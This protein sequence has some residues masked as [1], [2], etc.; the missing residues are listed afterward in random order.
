MK[1]KEA[2]KRMRILKLPEQ[3]ISD[4]IQSGKVYKHELGIICQLVE[5]EKKMIDDFEN[6]YKGIV[7]AVIQTKTD[8]GILYSLFYVSE[9]RSEWKDDVD[10]LKENTSMLYVINLE[11]PEFSE[12]GYIG[13]RKLKDGVLER[14]S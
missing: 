3:V 14:T 5:F 10:D 6:Q 13:F 4:F 2:V 12:F 8:V 9:H 7:Y 11:I 1:T